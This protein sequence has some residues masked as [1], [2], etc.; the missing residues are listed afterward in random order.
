MKE[1]DLTYERAHELFSYD[2][3]TG[4]LTR[5]PCSARSRVGGKVISYTDDDGY[6]RVRCGG[7]K[8]YLYRVHRIAWL[9]TYGSFP[10]HQIDH[11][12]HVRNDNR[13]CNLRAVD[14][15]ENTKNK[16][17]RSNNTSGVTGVSWYKRDEKWQA[18]VNVNGKAIHLGFYEDFQEAVLVRK[19][20]ERKYGFHVNHGIKQ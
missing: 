1:A 6:V 2:P 12:N 16:R 10:E 13:I 5:K 17:M 7:A 14:N 20:A 9:M 15:A 8:G 4:I 18:V 11:I 19:R 3:D